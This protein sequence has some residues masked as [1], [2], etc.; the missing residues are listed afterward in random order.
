MS[1]HC[2]RALVEEFLGVTYLDGEPSALSST[3]PTPEAFYWPDKTTEHSRLS[4]FGMTSELLMAD[5]GEEL[6]T[7]F[8]EVSL[9]KTSAQ[10][11]EATDSTVNEVGCGR[12]WLGLLA[13]FDRD[14]LSWRTPQCSLLGDSDEFSETWPR[15]GSMRNGEC[16]E[17]Q[18][19]EHPTNATES[20]LWPTPNCIGYRSDGELLLLSRKLSDRSEY[21]AMS[22][23]AANSKRERFWPTPCASASKGSS[24][25]ALVRKSGKSRENDRIDH[26]VM[27]SDGGQLNPEWVEWLMGWPIG[28]TELKPLATDRFQEW[29][30]QHSI[31]S[32]EVKNAA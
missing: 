18:T 7:W 4:R 11:D 21:L 17:R 24:P 1:W 5:R 20:G 26:A 22:S 2:S 10:L 13:R 23:R 15:W 8:R 25:A 14:S 12:K 3:T 29:R 31:C 16:W 30:Q 27:A 9:A 6:L 19:L 28:L 32:H